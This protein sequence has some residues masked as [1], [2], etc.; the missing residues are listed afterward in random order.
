MTANV[1][2]YG[3]EGAAVASPSVASHE[4][5]RVAQNS[6]DV[7]ACDAEET[8]SATT[9]RMG[10][11]WSGELAYGISGLLF[12][13]FGHPDLHARQVQLHVAATPSQQQNG[14]AWL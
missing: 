6:V 3:P 7:S 10:M 1:E 2:H 13:G 5:M 14:S 11:T 8:E 12:I 4:K 9:A